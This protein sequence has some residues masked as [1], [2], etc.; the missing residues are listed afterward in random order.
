MDILNICYNSESQLF[1]ELMLCKIMHN[2]DV[3]YI[4]TTHMCVVIKL[5]LNFPLP[6][7]HADTTLFI[8]SNLRHYLLKL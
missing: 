4:I 2:Q 5:I 1:F 8:Y 3:S 7:T 6:W